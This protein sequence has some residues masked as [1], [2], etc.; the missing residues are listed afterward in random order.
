MKSLIIIK[1]T[2]LLI[3]VN[4]NAVVMYEANGSKVYFWLL[5]DQSH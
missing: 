1:N 2:E 5:C 3:I 4:L